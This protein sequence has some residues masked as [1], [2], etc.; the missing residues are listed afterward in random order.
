MR[1][2]ERTVVEHV[3]RDARQVGARPGVDDV[4]AR[5]EQVGVRT[6]EG[7]HEAEPG[8]GLAGGEPGKAEE[9]D[10]GDQHPMRRD[11]V[12]LVYL[13]F[14]DDGGHGGRG[15]PDPWPELAW[16]FGVSL[17]TGES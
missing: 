15:D 8:G 6:R 12:H 17:L 3:D 4:P 1:A 13:G 10:G 9:G 11:E 16:G 2:Q 7:S 5:I 14:G